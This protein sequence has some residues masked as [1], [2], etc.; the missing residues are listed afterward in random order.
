MDDVM[1]K[2]PEPFNNPFAK[3]KPTGGA[4]PTAH[5]VS[6]GDS[7]ARPA[8][9][10]TRP[11]STPSAEDEAA[12]FLEAVG[13]A[14][15][16]P[17]AKRVVQEAGL[18]S[19]DVRTLPTDDVE[20]LARLAELVAD[21]EQFELSES[22]GGPA[23][24]VRGFDARVF[25][26]LRAGE[27]APGGSIDL[28]GLTREQARPALERF[29]ARER[30]LGHRCALV[31]TGRGLNSEA[32]VPVLRTEVPA[33]LTAARLA[34][35]VLAFCGAKPKDGGAGALYVLLRR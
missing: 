21:A 32:Q 15:R 9:P 16:P 5:G 33:W 23:G 11:R 20:S 14:R 27:F 35:A 26:R 6:K 2:K 3:L 8:R 25:R 19:D 10:A 31:V 18:A 7:P 1:S 4:K 13:T 34:R 28:H 22:D 17:G 12:L 30:E 29:L 24:W